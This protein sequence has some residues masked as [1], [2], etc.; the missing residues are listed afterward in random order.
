MQVSLAVTPLVLFAVAASITPGPNNLLVMR[1]G[2]RHGLGPTWPHI[3]GIELGFGGLIV[4]T[5]AG[6][7]ALLLA[8]PFAARVLQWLC[9]AY[10]L[11]LAF[12]MLRE[13]VAD[14][15]LHA[16]AAPRPMGI[17]EAMAFQLVNP[18]AWMMAVTG[19]SGFGTTERSSWLELLV[20]VLVFVGV[21]FPSVAIWALWGAAIHRVLHRP[22]AR[23][24]FNW[25]MALLIVISALLM[26]RGEGLV[27]PG[28]PGQPGEGRNPDRAQVLHRAHEQQRQ[29]HGGDGT[30]PRP[31]RTVNGR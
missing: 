29:H 24:A 4:L 3:L 14:D 9:V 26:L 21:G 28:A 13:S 23:R 15:A 25:A 6:V 2:A 8:V 11:W 20:V 16:A 30:G 27:A 7:G 12:G 10:L 19:V 31:G 5:W 17:A 18:K 1:S 22:A